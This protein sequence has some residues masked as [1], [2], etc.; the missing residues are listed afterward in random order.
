[1][2]TSIRDTEGRAPLYLYYEHCYG[3]FVDRE[4]ARRLYEKYPRS[5][6]C[7]RGVDRIKLLMSILSAPTRDGGAG[8]PLDKL[9]RRKACDAAFPLHEEDELKSLEARWIRMWA[10]PAQLPSERVRSYFGEKIAFYYLFLA[11]ATT[12]FSYAA[13]IGFAVFLNTLISPEA[14]NAASVPYFCAFMGLWATFFIE[15]WKRKESRHAM[16]WGTIGFEDV[17]RDRPEYAEDP[18]TVVTNSPIDGMETTYFPV[19]VAA[20][21]K[22]QSTGVIVLAI[23]GVCIVVY[24]IFLLNVALKIPSV[25]EQ[26]DPHS[27]WNK[28]PSFELRST[29]IGIVT[30]IQIMVLERLYLK[31]AE[32]M[33]DREGHRTDTAY[34]DALIGKTF[35]FTFVNAYATFFYTAFFKQ[36]QSQ[37]PGAGILFPSSKQRLFECQARRRRL[38]DHQRVSVPRGAAAGAMAEPTAKP[39]AEP[40]VH[41]YA[42]DATWR[43]RPR[44]PRAASAEVRAHTPRETRPR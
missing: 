42:I 21:R 24:S 19:D 20:K 18:L 22:T 29:I 23:I 44:T 6:S 4:D 32:K 2:D 38:R 35:V 37:Q 40:E 17:E 31:L 25:E 12:Y 13:V 10:R 14:E 8:L 33:T 39:T 36:V 5:E 15:T 7:F 16:E 1:M 26:I 27:W 28:L 9:V 34:E 30:T 41:R 3:P 43:E 11:H